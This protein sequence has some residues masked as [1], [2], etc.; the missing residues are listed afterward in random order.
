[1]LATD[2][3]H[4]TRCVQ[5]SRP[6]SPVDVYAL[7]A[8]VIIAVGIGIRFYGASSMSLWVDEAVIANRVSVGKV[9]GYLAYPASN[10]PLG[11]LLISGWIAR[12]YNSELVLR[13]TSIVPSIA[14][15]VLVTQI[16][17]HLFRSRGLALLAS[18]SVA[19]NA[20]SV[21]FAKDFKPYALEQCIAILFLYLYLRWRRGGSSRVLAILGLSIA[22]GPLFS[23]TAVFAAPLYGLA[24]GLELHRSGDWRSIAWF[25]LCVA[26]AC[27]AAVVQYALM[28]AQTPPE[29]FTSSSASYV[30]GVRVSEIPTWGLER[31]GALILDF[32]PIGLEPPDLHTLSG[33]L[34]GA[35][36]L[37]GWVLGASVMAVRR[38]ARLFLVLVGPVLVPAAL[39]LVF[40][41]PF[42]PER[43]NLYMIPL[44]TLTVFFGWDELLARPSLSWARGC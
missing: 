1:M 38:Q 11:Y 44:V 18:A 4:S 14:T 5:E 43:L 16:G 30:Q 31:L 32:G 39:A 20:W 26:L 24:V 9:A 12:V 36:Y 17:F 3:Y 35:I 33:A 29:L 41:W 42:G 37:G 15:L 25:Q 40:P 22:I 8:V 28:G 19:L 27:I 21:T 2:I 6:A 7:V 34:V 23:H 10:R 13:L